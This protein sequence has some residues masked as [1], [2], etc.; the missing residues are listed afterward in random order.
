M[1][2]NNLP[3]KAANTIRFLAA[4]AVQ[5]ANSGH[6][7]MPMGMAD[8]AVAL[9][10]NFM[11]HNPQDPNW[12]NRDRFILSAGHGSML[13]YSLLH[14]TGYDLPMEEL[15]SFRQ[16]ESK[17][18]GHP[19]YGHTVGIE[20]T[21]GPLGQGISNSVG[22]ALAEA[23]LAEKFNKPDLPIVDHYTYVICSDGDLQEGISHEA[24]ALAG[25][26]GLGKLIVLYD[27]N[28]ISIDGP[29]SLSFSEDVLQRFQAYGWDVNHVEDGQNGELIQSAIT[30][31][32][33]QTDKPSIIACRTTIG[34]GSPNKAGTSGI[35]G[36]PMG[37]EE[38]KLT[39]EAFDWPVD[40]KFLVPGDVR[41]FMDAREAGA[42]AQE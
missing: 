21:T 10:T 25:H 30:A 18:P 12:A 36:S 6:P 24:C 3:K 7:G 42:A 26:L 34:Y 4:D 14:L 40:E 32:K 17:T 39:K 20:T 1:S 38:I 11:T 28:G 9:W 23:W 27:D 29:T 8:A 2:D 13:I 16:W 37:E 33:A 22:F 5:K 15:K 41:A 19:E 35:H 31:A